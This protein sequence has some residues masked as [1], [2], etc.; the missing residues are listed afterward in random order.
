MDSNYLQFLNNTTSTSVERLA[1]LSEIINAIPQ[2]RMAKLAK[3]NVTWEELDDE[4]M[5]T[6]NVEFYP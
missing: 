3:M 1:A 2:E 5:P 6:L 4:M